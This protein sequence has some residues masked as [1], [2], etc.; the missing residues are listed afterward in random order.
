MPNTITA[1]A[2]F[3]DSWFNG[4]ASLGGGVTNAEKI[5]FDEVEE[6]TSVPTASDFTAG[7]KIVTYDGKM[8]VKD[9]SGNIK[10]FN[11]ENLDEVK[12]KKGNYK[13]TKN[14][15]K[16][17]ITLVQWKNKLYMYE[18]YTG[19]VI[20]ISIEELDEIKKLNR[21]PVSSDFQDGITI[22]QHN[23][24]LFFKK[25]NGNV[26]PLG[27]DVGD[28]LK[29]YNT[30]TDF[31]NDKTNLDSRKGNFVTVKNSSD[32]SKNGIWYYDGTAWVLILNTASIN[33]DN[34][35]AKYSAYFT[36][37]TNGVDIVTYGGDLYKCIGTNVKGK[38]PTDKAY[39][40]QITNNEI[41]GVQNITVNGSPLSVN[42]LNIIK[43]GGSYVLPISGSDSDKISVFYD[44]TTGTNNIDI[45]GAEVGN[46]GNSSVALR[47]RGDMATFVR[48][49]GK[50]LTIAQSNAPTK[51]EVVTKDGNW[52]IEPN[53]YAIIKKNGGYWLGAGQRGDR[54]IISM[55][56]VG[57][58]P[59][60]VKSIRRGNGVE[61]LELKNVG[62]VVEFVHNGDYWLLGSGIKDYRKIKVSFASSSQI[63][64]F[65][66]GEVYYDLQSFGQIEY[67]RVN[68]PANKRISGMNASH[69]LNKGVIDA[70][71]GLIYFTP[72]T[73]YNDIT[74]NFGLED[75]LAPTEVWR[76]V[77]PPQ[78]AISSAYC[79]LYTGGD[80][81]P[82]HKG[83]WEGVDR[84]DIYT[85]NLI[86]NKVAVD[87][88]GINGA[89]RLFDGEKY[90]VANNGLTLNGSS[91][92][93]SFWWFQTKYNGVYILGS[94]QTGQANKGLHIGW[95]TSN[96]FTVAFY[97]DDFDI[98][99]NRSNYMQKWTH[100]LIRF[101][102][103]NKRT[104]IWV[105]GQNKGSH[106]HRDI[107][108]GYLDSVNCALGANTNG[109]FMS[110]LR[111]WESG[112]GGDL[113]SSN[114][115][116]ELYAEERKKLLI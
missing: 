91:F 103:N 51:M 96:K 36:Y 28:F 12:I 105:N 111:V 93:I 101:N 104:V 106:Y 18:E 8:Y 71:Q 110:N 38:L 56:Y 100:F 41:T 19:K 72:D 68:V 2:G 64:D 87:H 60:T 49:G 86:F 63:V 1:P 80:F 9:A 29:S 78:C 113:I 4:S 88:S 46:G 37:D 115:V 20:E 22:I 95:R 15:F 83:A 55:Q 77:R 114:G 70:E 58:Y 26:I 94:K 75:T 47:R 50:W 97:A 62:D 25:D 16:N 74:L 34:I 39:W 31:N 44:C 81:F 99:L 11:V 54:I 116:A 67:L 6:V 112:S 48:F 32:Y 5:D 23:D 102:K 14:D 35:V 73:K 61:D 53:Q 90:E 30:Y 59:V 40:Q 21:D 13:P 108:K 42:K 7:V 17:G 109:G 69:V 24:K 85:N 79:W 92:V 45:T 57:N 76:T 98:G 65:L 3:T 82:R 43:V 89:M 10:E 33:L 107:F 66:D 52:N 84:R 27:L